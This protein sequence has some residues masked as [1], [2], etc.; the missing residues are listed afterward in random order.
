MK[1]LFVYY[2]QDIRKKYLKK[3]MNIW[4]SKYRSTRLE[5]VR[6]IDVGLNPDDG[7][8]SYMRL[9]NIDVNYN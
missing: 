1:K 8:A 5:Y 7:L 6:K 2:N 9:L 3:Y 4:I